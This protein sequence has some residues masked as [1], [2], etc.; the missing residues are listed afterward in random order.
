M[1]MIDPDMLLGAY[2]IG[3]FPMADSR[4]ADDVF[5]VEPLRRAMIPIEDFKM[6]RSLKKIVRSDR[7]TVTRDAAF[8]EVVR[9]CADRPETWINPLLEKSY[10]AL[11]ELGNAHSIECWRGGRL[12]GGLYGV[13]L[14]PAF[15]GESMFSAERD[16]SK[17]ALAWLV[18]RLR[19]GRFKL[20]DCQFMTPHLKSLGA[21]ELPQADYV[22]RLGELLETSRGGDFTALD[23]LL[24][25]SSSSSSSST[26]DSS[27]GN[28]IAQLLGQT[29]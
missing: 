29:S 15:F 5:W 25:S 2:S 21:V 16:A 24:S 3:V 20:L 4:S 14:G 18:A 9:H 13:R 17:V 28:L 6:S 1:A 26:E 11:H 7:F 19:H 10:A 27:P 8:S 12:A 23:A 22:A